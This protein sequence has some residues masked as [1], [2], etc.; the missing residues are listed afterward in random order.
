VGPGA[1]LVVAGAGVE[2]AV[3]DADEPV[4][5]APHGVVMGISGGAVL[6]GPPGRANDDREPPSFT[7]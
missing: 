1:V 7:V 2:A 6:C 3:E 4:G 5:E